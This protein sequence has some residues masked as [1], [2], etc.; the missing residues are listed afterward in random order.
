MG[1]HQGKPRQSRA[2]VLNREPEAP[3]NVSPDK[4]K[5][6]HEL[7]T[8]LLERKNRITA[9]SFAVA[10]ILK[11]IRDER[12]YEALGYAHFQDYA[13]SVFSTEATAHKLIS[14]YETYYIRKPPM[15]PE[16][17]DLSGIDYDKLYMVRPMLDPKKPE[18]S[19]E[20]VE[21][22]RQLSRNDLREVMAEERRKR[23]GQSEPEVQTGGNGDPFKEINRK[24]MLLVGKV[25]NSVKVDRDSSLVLVAEKTRLRVRPDGDL[26]DIRVTEWQNDK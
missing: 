22:A 7:H 14:V 8:D 3:T 6:A 9:E 12:F 23:T 24:L 2:L 18:E 26:I 16:N 4:A 15:L 25:I 10:A 19:A 21:K 17:T 20:W 1:A 5:I 11:R 13:R